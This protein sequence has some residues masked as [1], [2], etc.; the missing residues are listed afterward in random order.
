MTS[1]NTETGPARLLKL[2]SRGT[3]W[4]LQQQDNNQPK[5]FTSQ[6]DCCCSRCHNA[7]IIL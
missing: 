4:E 5:Y 2:V 3:V 1:A 6:P 7:Y